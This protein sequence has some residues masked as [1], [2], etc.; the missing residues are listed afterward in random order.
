MTELFHRQSRDARRDEYVRIAICGI[1]LT[2]AS[3]VWHV[4]RSA[5]IHRAAQSSVGCQ[6]RTRLIAAALRTRY[7]G[8][9]RDDVLWSPSAGPTLW[10]HSLP[11][12]GWVA[13]QT[14]SN[15]RQLPD[16]SWHW[17]SQLQFA[18]DHLLLK[19]RIS[20]SP[21]VS[22]PPLDADG[23]GRWEFVVEFLATP[24]ATQR[25]RDVRR[26]A[27]VRL[28]RDGNEV[29]WVGLVDANAWAFHRARIEPV[30]RDEDGDAG[31]E[32]H[33]VP[34]VFARG[35]AQT[36]AFKELPTV[37]IL[38]WDRPGGVLRERLTSTD[39]TLLSW[40]APPAPFRVA[41][42]EPLDKRLADLLPVPDGFGAA[43]PQTASAP[44][45]TD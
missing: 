19:G 7:A 21:G 9:P 23:D 3:V 29:A 17:D 13:W 28:G 35:R 15:P 33:F 42:Q 6:A 31:S 40:T 25:E 45:A 22:V 41:V 20:P 16:T 34:L 12:L 27:V 5:M 8:V 37:A 18:D 30:W 32:L 38:E 14:Y 4:T 26:V 36:P 11:R 2:C 43:T 44:N 10:T 39:G 1:A 24:L